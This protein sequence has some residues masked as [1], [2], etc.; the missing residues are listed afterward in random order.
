MRKAHL[1]LA[2]VVLLAVS[3]F[4]LVACSNTVREENPNIIRLL[5]TGDEVEESA[6]WNFDEFIK[7]ANSERKYAAT[8]HFTEHN[9]FS[10]WVSIFM[11]TINIDDR[12]VTHSETDSRRYRLVA[13]THILMTDNGLLHPENLNNH[14]IDE[15]I[16]INHVTASGVLDGNYIRLRVIRT[17]I[18]MESITLS[19]TS[20]DN[21]IGIGGSRHIITQITP[22]NASFPNSNFIIESI[23]IGGII[24]TGVAIENYAV[25]TF[26]GTLAQI[27]ALANMNIGDEINIVA[28][29]IADNTIRSNVLTLTVVA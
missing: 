9:G 22:L 20:G 3:S 28:I 26:W 18:P 16:R 25:I 5:V 6:D 24:M 17:P 2:G 27:V 15:I 13:N 12:I 21:T 8:V 7:H 19:V 4:I 23:V 29:G 10:V 11:R 14:N 1:I